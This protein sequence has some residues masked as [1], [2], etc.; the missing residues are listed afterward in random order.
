MYKPYSGLIPTYR[1][2]NPR[3]FSRGEWKYLDTTIS[4]NQDT[5]GAMTLINGL[6]PGNSASQRVGQKVE[7]R[8][9]QLRLQSIVTA[10]TGVD[11]VQRIILLR[12]GQPNGA[13]PTA[14]TDF[15]TPGT[16]YGQ[17]A[18]TN[19]KRFRILMDKTRYLN[20]SGEPYSGYFMKAYI[21]FRRPIVTEYNAGVSGTIADIATNSLYLITIG[22]Q[23]A[24]VTAGITLGTCRIRYTDM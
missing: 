13:P 7:I 18:L 11:Q 24:G 14:L 21:K 1:G 6:V 16:I 22:Q 15:L 9:I 10:T 20:A 5:T 23:N 2:F 19:R 17:R 8:S 4:S 3:A 12:D